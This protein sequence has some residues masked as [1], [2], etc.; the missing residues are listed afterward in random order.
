V[1]LRL[2]ST[3]I[4]YELTEQQTGTFGQGVANQTLLLLLHAILI[5]VGKVLTTL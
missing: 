3:K 1:A 4:R 5:Q 2:Y